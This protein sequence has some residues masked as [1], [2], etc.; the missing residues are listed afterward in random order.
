MSTRQIFWVVCKQ[1]GHKSTKE[2]NSGPKIEPWGP[3]IFIIN[4][5]LLIP[6]FRVNNAVPP[7]LSTNFCYMLWSTM[8]MGESSSFPPQEFWMFWIIS[9]IAMFV[10]ILFRKPCWQGVTMLYV[11]M[12]SSTFNV[13]I[14]TN[15]IWDTRSVERSCNQ[16][17]HG[18]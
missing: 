5:S 9:C 12:V 8:M 10:G 2:K 4:G 15:D 3:P 1:R 6:L 7:L 14:C 16:H 18:N 11:C 13:C 17:A